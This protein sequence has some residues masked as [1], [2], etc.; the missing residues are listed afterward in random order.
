MERIYHI[1]ILI[2]F[3][4]IK[5]RRIIPFYTTDYN[6][7]IFIFFSDRGNRFFG[8]GVPFLCR[9]ID[10]LVEQLEN[11]VVLFGEFILEFFPNGNKA[12][13]QF[14]ALHKPALL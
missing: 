13:L 9:G 12:A 10:H 6:E 7:A 1:L 11:H 4:I 3:Y 5:C 2:N 14:F 8:K